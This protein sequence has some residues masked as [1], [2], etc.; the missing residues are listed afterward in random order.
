MGQ[1]E[2]NTKVVIA[3]A[4]PA[5]AA[6]SI[7]LSKLGIAHVILDK[8]AFPRDKVCGDACSGRTAQVIRTANP[9]WLTEMRAKPQFFH[10]TW[11]MTV[12]APSGRQINIPLVKAGG[13]MPEAM[14]FTVERLIFDNFLFSKIDATY[15]TVYQEATVTEINRTDQGIKVLAATA[16]GSLTLNAEV[17]LGADGDKSMV[18][19]SFMDQDSLKAAAVG[20]R[21]YYSGVTGLY[22]LNYIE[23]HYLPELPSGYLWIFPLPDGRANVGIG[24]SSKVIREKKVKLRELFIH[25]LQQHPRF[26]GQFEGAKLEGKIDGW[27]VPIYTGKEAMCGDRFL[28]LGD[29]AHLVDPFSGEGIGNALYSGMVG[30]QAVAAALAV[31]DFSGVFFRSHYEDVIYKAL[32]PELNQNAAAQRIFLKQWV[33]NMFFKKVFKSETLRT[34]ISHMFTDAE[35]YKQFKKPSFYWKVLINK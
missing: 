8:S 6:A 13:V 24:M 5:G 29:A 21:A 11:G 20:L 10:P 19:R 27:G 22:N 14:G 23:L 4:G 31:N 1:Q 34:A 16:N 3:G 9:D 32:G 26:K 33:F 15:A 7:F 12:V 17:V 35:M 25:L 2:V 28:L 30:A 18:R